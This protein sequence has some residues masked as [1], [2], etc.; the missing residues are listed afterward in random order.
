MRTYANSPQCVPSRSSMCTGRRTDQIEAWSNEKG[1]AASEDG[2]LDKTCIYF[3]GTDQC[4]AWAKMQNYSETIFSGL[5]RLGAD[6]VGRVF[7]RYR[8]HG[9]RCAHQS[10]SSLFTIQYIGRCRVHSLQ[11]APLTHV[12]LRRLPPED[13]KPLLAI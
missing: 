11:R 13:P 5:Q 4:A 8:A 7:E 2:T 10:S 12:S 3:Y 6:S 1:L 9:L